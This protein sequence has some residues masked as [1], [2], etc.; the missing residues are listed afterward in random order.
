MYF[1]APS[2]SSE[3][4]DFLQ[5]KVDAVYSTLTS[6][7]DNLT[8]DNI[9]TVGLQQSVSSS[10]T[11]KL[12]GN[13]SLNLNLVAHLSLFVSKRRLWM[14]NGT[15]ATPGIH[16]PVFFPWE[17]RVFATLLHGLIFLLGVAGNILVVIVVRRTKSMHVPTYCYLESLAIADL[18]VIW[19][20]IPEAIVSYHVYAHQYV[21][22][23]VGCSLLIF[24][25]FLGINASCLSI[26]AFTVERFIAICQ[27]LR[28][29]SI[30]TLQ[31]AKK[32]IIGLWIVALLSASPWLGLTVIVRYSHSPEIDICEFRVS[33][34][35]YKFIFGA[36]LLL[37][38]VIPLIT[39]SI[40]YSKIGFALRK[41]TPD[42]EHAGT[43]R[44]AASD[45]RS[46][47][48]PSTAPAVDNGSAN[49]EAKLVE[50]K[51]C[52][53]RTQSR[54]GRNGTC[55]SLIVG[56]SLR[57][58]TSALSIRNARI[59]VVRMLLVIVVLF[60][61]L[62]L[63]YRGIM[64]YNTFAK[65]PALNK[66]LMLFAKTCIFL[67]SSINPILYNAMSKRF[68][69]AFSSVLACQQRKTLPV[70]LHLQATATAVQQHVRVLP[71]RRATLMASRERDIDH[72]QRPTQRHDRNHIKW[73][74]WQSVD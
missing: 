61:V 9:L 26:L 17:Y 6:N 16:V 30:C 44:A 13:Y 38:Y 22:G 37:F 32:I 15:T 24:L 34:Q 69:K 19:A 60:A 10:S 70:Q 57:S 74:L 64:L 68:R 73:R 45:N 54:A 48:Y 27:P 25:S 46:H 66:W 8:T 4:I 7:M 40:L 49:H 36:D 39:A 14:D 43:R 59:K 56:D 41:R 2:L 11:H 5:H 53:W 63:P 52:E 67:N 31:R 62:W 51:P 12:L 3:S 35:K 55:S 23:Q 21:F 29:K 71:Q 33:R 72:E 18:L 58:G 50:R 20:C 65:R 1:I 47:D 42:R 28:A